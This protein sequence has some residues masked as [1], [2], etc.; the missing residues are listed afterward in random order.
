[1]NI[2]AQTNEKADLTRAW[3]N[4][5]LSIAYEWTLRLVNIALTLLVLQLYA[6]A[7]LYAPVNVDA[8]YYLPTAIHLSQGLVPINE[9]HLGY[10]PLALY[11]LAFV[12]KIVGDGNS[13]YQYFLGTIFFFQFS[14][15]YLVYRLGSFIC[16]QRSLRYLSAILTLL[17]FYI[18]EG[19]GIFLEAPTTFFALLGAYA[20]LSKPTRCLNL[21]LA[22]SCGFLSFF[23]KQ[24]GLASIPAYAGFCLLRPLPI[25]QRIKMIVFVVVGFALPLLLVIV[26]CLTVLDIKLNAV[27]AGSARLGYFTGITEMGSFQE[28]FLHTCRFMLPVPL[29]LFLRTARRSPSFQLIFL[30]CLFFSLPLFVRHFLHYF[31]L[32]IPYA[33]L[34][35]LFLNEGI[36]KISPALAIAFLPIFSPLIYK[37]FNFPLWKESQI[38]RPQ[39]IALAKRINAVWPPYTRTLAYA[40]PS[41]FVTCRFLTI[42]NL[43]PG[44][45]Y[46][47]KFSAQ[48]VNQLLEKAD[49]IFIDRVN[50]G[51]FL[52]SK[53]RIEAE[54]GDFDALLTKKGFRLTTSID[55]RYE[56]WEK[57]PS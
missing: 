43:F 9:I 44:Y 28:F 6:D 22:G 13:S 57:S 36:R 46:M 2:A 10:T 41:I 32:M 5:T 33:M 25:S 24:Y 7:L 52:A 1:M 39:Q 50:E 35:A 34:L 42:D 30:L 45:T 29:L 48:V 26:A 3:L 40:E 38:A 53:Q 19:D 14:C 11:I 54:Y 51:Y 12:A 21:I 56:F 20:L 27:G 4:V 15:A 18:H 49:R 17:C 37:G 16:P 31:G 23:S 47:E 55:R 8:G